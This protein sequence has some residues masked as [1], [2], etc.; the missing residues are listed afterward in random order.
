MKIVIAYIVI[1][2]ITGFIIMGIDKKRA[3]KHMWRVPEKTL[4]LTALFGGSL[5]IL[6]GMKNFRHKTK[7]LTFCVGIPAIILV[8]ILIV[9]YI[10]K[11]YYII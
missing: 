5:G 9:L 11:N 2:N 10:I 4:F 1:I 7:H 6:L 8:Q 3:I